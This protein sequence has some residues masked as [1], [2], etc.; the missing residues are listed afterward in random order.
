MR[1]WREVQG[2]GGAWSTV[3]SLDLGPTF[4]R[5]Q[6]EGRRELTVREEEWREWI[7]TGGG[8][9]EERGGWESEVGFQGQSWGA[10][11][12]AGL[13]S[14]PRRIPRS[15]VSQAVS[16]RQQLCTDIWGG[17]YFYTVINTIHCFT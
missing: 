16:P 7:K 17:N 13:L 4:G 5:D 8:W 11:V 1:E 3:E 12:G 9:E 14:G 2:M 10:G 15:P 6:T